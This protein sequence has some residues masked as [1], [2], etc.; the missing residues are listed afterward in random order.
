MEKLYSEIEINDTV[1][2]LGYVEPKWSDETLEEMLLR[3]H[4]WDIYL[5]ED[6]FTRCP[7]KTYYPRIIKGMQFTNE[8]SQIV[9][10]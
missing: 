3:D 1:Q 4:E 10:N 9:L 7:Y 2:F 6:Q 8:N 5:F